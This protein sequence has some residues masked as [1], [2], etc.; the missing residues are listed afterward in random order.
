MSNE[1]DMLIWK[2][3]KDL[4]RARLALGKIYNIV[5]KVCCAKTKH[6]LSFIARDDVDKIAERN[7]LRTT[8]LLDSISTVKSGVLK[9]R[10]IY[11]PCCSEDK[12]RYCGSKPCLEDIKRDGICHCGL[13]EKGEKND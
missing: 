3:D 4:S 1:Q 6:A 9:E 13:Y 11:C 2:L 5:G 8:E 7:Q 10:W 12:S